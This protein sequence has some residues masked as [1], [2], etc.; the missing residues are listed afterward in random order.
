MQPAR[1]SWATW[2]CKYG[3]RSLVAPCGPLWPL[4]APCGPLLVVPCGPLWFLVAPCR[5][6]QCTTRA[7]PPP[8]H[9][10]PAPRALH[11]MRLGTLLC[12]MSLVVAP[13]RG[14]RQQHVLVPRLFPCPSLLLFTWVTALVQLQLLLCAWCGMWDMLCYGA[15]PCTLG[16]YS[17]EARFLGRLSW[18]Q[19]LLSSGGQAVPLVSV[20]LLSCDC[21]SAGRGPR[22]VD[23]GLG[24]TIGHASVCPQER[25]GLAVHAPPAEWLIKALSFGSG[26]LPLSDIPALLLAV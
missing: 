21:D 14:H 13:P 2:T 1:R 25:S 16:G 10:T 6:Q 22:G 19:R 9:V 15:C 7:L 26:S 17:C 11:T 8:P 3:G 12:A 24:N 23:L 5:A 4:V 20:R 18:Q